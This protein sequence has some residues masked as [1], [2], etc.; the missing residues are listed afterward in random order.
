MPATVDTSGQHTKRPIIELDAFVEGTL[1]H[2]KPGLP[3]QRPCASAITRS[4]TVH[5]TQTIPREGASNS[6]PR[7]VKALLVTR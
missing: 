4:P 6:A 2:D 5:R 7:E 3:E 1:R